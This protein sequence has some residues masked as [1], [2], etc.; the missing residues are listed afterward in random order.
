MKILS[1]N[2]DPFRPPKF[3]LGFVLLLFGVLI[4]IHEPIFGLI[5]ISLS[6]LLLTS[7][8]LEIDSEKKTFRLYKSTFGLKRGGWHPL[9]TYT[10]QIILKK[11]GK[12]KVLGPHLAFEMNFSSS[13][14]ELYLTDSTHRSRLY[15]KSFD[16]ADSAKVY[17]QKLVKTLN[18][19]LENYSPKISEKTR[20][21]I[22][23]RKK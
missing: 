22:E 19:P 9:S 5:L 6:L 23:K 2:Q 14:Y 1:L 13:V 20:E 17:A 10:A 15:I 11:T 3:V 21:R 7:Y 16:D 12:R 8:G 4:I 18:L